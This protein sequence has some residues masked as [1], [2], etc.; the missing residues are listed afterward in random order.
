[1]VLAHAIERRSAHQEAYDRKFV[2]QRLA[3]EVDE[4]TYGQ[5]LLRARKLISGGSPRNKSAAG[6]PRLVNAAKTGAERERPTSAPE[7]H[8][9]RDGAA[10]A[11]R[12]AAR[13]TRQL[14]AAAPPSRLAGAG[15]GADGAASHRAP[16]ATM[17]ELR[18]AVAEETQAEAEEEQRR[19]QQRE[20]E[21]AAARAREEEPKRQREREADEAATAQAAAAAATTTTATASAGAEA[22]EAP[23]P[24]A[25]GM[26][27][28][29]P[30]SPEM[31]VNVMAASEA[32]GAQGQEPAR[33]PAPTSVE[34]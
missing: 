12:A 26:I 18:A 25:A 3:T 5:I 33:A 15:R 22:A 13:P 4:T 32:G 30:P 11:G 6:V 17:Q 16:P 14:G 9:Q 7:A 29:A 20:E 10:G 27:E 19:R 28:A 21:A 31:A 23:P 2:D 1:M 8:S 24:S 34:A